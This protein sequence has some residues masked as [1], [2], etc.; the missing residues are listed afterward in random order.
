MIQK[1]NFEEII[2]A[3]RV[4]KLFKRLAGMD[5]SHESQPTRLSHFRWF[6]L[7]RATNQCLTTLSLVETAILAGVITEED[8]LD[9]R[10]D[11]RDL[12]AKISLGRY[13]ASP[14]VHNLQRR[15]HKRQVQT[16]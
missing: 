1:A 12:E 3:F 14:L 5:P 6:R 2:N 10:V 16:F 13:V 9:S 8:F 4:N 15:I 11:F 7:S